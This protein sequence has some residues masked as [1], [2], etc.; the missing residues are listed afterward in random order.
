MKG[1]SEREVDIYYVC[2]R[3]QPWVIKDS[4]QAYVAPIPYRNGRCAAA[5]RE[6]Q[7][8]IRRVEDEDEL[9]GYLVGWAIRED[10]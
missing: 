8:W 7:H 1:T 2:R 4:D 3:S 9:F 6:F 5:T 10:W